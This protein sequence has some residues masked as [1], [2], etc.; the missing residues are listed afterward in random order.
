MCDFPSWIEQPDGT[1]L[2]LTDKDLCHF[3][4]ENEHDA[5]GHHGIRQVFSG[6]NGIDRE[7][8]PPPLEIARA[9]KAGKM[10]SLMRLGGYDRVSEI[11]PG[12]WEGV[13]EDGSWWQNRHKAGELDGL[14][15]GVHEDGSWW[16]NRYKAGERD[17]L[18][19]GVRADGSWWQ[20][21]YKA[22]ELMSSCSG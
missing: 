5:V 19:E 11:E 7:G 18:S 3:R 13:R 9:I 21:R 4:P 22:G 1:L 16:Q 14:S 8:F 12:L 20:N 2:Y 17:G 10:A 6:A 15:E